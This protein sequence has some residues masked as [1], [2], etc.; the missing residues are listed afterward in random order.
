MSDDVSP[1]G[2]P[3]LK[4]PPLKDVV[5]GIGDKLRESVD[6]LRNLYARRRR[7]R[8]IKVGLFLVG[9]YVLFFHQHDDDA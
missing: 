8:M 4:P 7:A 3:I 2:L 6:R 5:H 1:E 9:A